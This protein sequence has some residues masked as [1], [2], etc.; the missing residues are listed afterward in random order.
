[1]KLSALSFLKYALIVGL[2]G[3]VGFITVPR[4]GSSLK[5]GD[6][7]AKVWFYNEKAHRLYE[8]PRDTVSPSSDGVRAVVV[9]FSDNEKDPRRCKIAYLEKYGPDLAA[10]LERA[11]V[12]HLAQ[13]LF[14]EEMPARASVYFQDNTFVRRET[15]EIWYPSSS[16]DGKQIMSEWRTWR[17]PEEQRPMVSV[18]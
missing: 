15:E 3:A 17:G 1:V 13:H 8:V 6:A 7:A 12:A 16:A 2:I 9:A 10:L 4:I 5:T 18:P 11:R 14:T